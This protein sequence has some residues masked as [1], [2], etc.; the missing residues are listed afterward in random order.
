MSSHVE[1]VP[2]GGWGSKTMPD[3]Q[4]MVARFTIQSR[5]CTRVSE[6]CHPRCGGLQHHFPTETE[7]LPALPVFRPLGL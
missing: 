4:I 6:W 5:Q 1:V 7:R 2:V 3:G